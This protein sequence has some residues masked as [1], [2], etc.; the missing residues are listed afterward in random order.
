MAY[1]YPLANVEFMASGRK[2]TG[3]GNM[4]NRTVLHIATRANH[5]GFHIA[6]D[7]TGGPDRNIIADL[8]IADDHSC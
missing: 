8:H 3:M 5:N 1:G 4:Q 6:S 7:Y 2:I